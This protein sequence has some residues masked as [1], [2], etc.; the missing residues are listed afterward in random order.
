MAVD[1][2]VVVMKEAYASATYGR[3]GITG[4]FSISHP[5][6][7]FIPCNMKPHSHIVFEL[8][9]TYMEEIYVAEANRSL[10]L[11]QN[12]EFALLTLATTHQQKKIGVILIELFTHDTVLG[13]THAFLKALRR[14]CSEQKVFLVVDDTMMSVRCGRV[15]SH[16]YYQT[17]FVPDFVIAGKVWLTGMLWAISDNAH[18]HADEVKCLNGVVTCA[19]DSI[20]FLKVLRFAEVLDTEKI[21]ESVNKLHFIISNHLNTLKQN[22]P[23]RPY[24][25]RNTSE[26]PT[27]DT[28]LIIRGLGC[29]WFTT[30]IFKD[31]Q[32]KVWHNRLLPTFVATQQEIEGLQVTGDLD[33]RE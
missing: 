8:S 19:I 2:E 15:F 29:I 24:P 13:L 23:K 16:E 33:R 21:L 4:K 30:M 12:E 14:W 31:Q 11:T 25:L 9:D 28:P 1:G 3:M 10:S 7:Q 20:L 22:S 18:Q 5:L 6:S 26:T 32:W 17:V 27:C